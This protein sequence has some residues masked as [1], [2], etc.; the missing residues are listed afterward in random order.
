MLAVD[1]R[2][3]V[4]VGSMAFTVALAVLAVLAVVPLST[5]LHVRHHHVWLWTCLAGAVLGFA[6]LPLIARHRASGRLG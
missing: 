4:L 2:R 3:V 5:P 1:A 6:S